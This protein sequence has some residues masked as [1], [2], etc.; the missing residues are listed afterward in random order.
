MIK[1]LL[2]IALVLFVML[3]TSCSSNDDKTLHIY[4]WTYYIPDSLL[5]KF[6]QETGYKVV[7]DNYSSNEEM[8]AKISAGGGKGFDLVFP[9]ADYTQ[10]MIKFDLIQKIDKTKLTNLQY[11]TPLALESAKSYDPNL[12]YSIP[13]FVG[14]AGIAVNTALAP[15]DYE[16]SW[17]IFADERLK[18]K[19]TLLDDMREVM[20]DALITLGYSSNTTDENEIQAAADKINKEWKPNIIKFDAESY[21]KG[22]ASGDIVVAH[23]Y[24]ESIIGELSEEKL[25]D[26]DIFIPQEGGCMYIDNMVIPKGAQNI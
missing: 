16:R 12:E 15:K 22:F 20:G 11:L 1:K 4:N 5:A 13:Y 2:I 3:F 25:K 10:I 18:G 9:S 26:V 21:A 24:P 23:C 19:M 8:Y 6:T 14:A 17:E 7:V